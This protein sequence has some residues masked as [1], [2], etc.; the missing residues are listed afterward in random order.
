[1]ATAHLV[2]QDFT[3]VRGLDRRYGILLYHVTGIAGPTS[4]G[5]GPVWSQSNTNQT[6]FSAIPFTLG[7][8]HPDPG[9]TGA[10]CTSIRLVSGPWWQPDGT[11]EAMV[12][13]MFDSNR[14]WGSAFRESWSSDPA[15]EKAM[16]LAWT[17]VS[18][19]S[20]HPNWLEYAVP[21]V[22]PAFV[23]IVPC[24]ATGIT[25]DQKAQIYKAV[26]QKFTLFGIPYVFRT[27]LLVHTRTDQV[28]V[29][30]QFFTKCPVAAIAAGAIPGVDTDIPKL[31][32]LEEYTRV[33]SV[34][35]GDPSIQ[36]QPVTAYGADHDPT[37]LPF[38]GNQ[39]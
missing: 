26:G 11:G 13:V 28:I 7:Q 35:A 3:A 16:R 31:D 39:L 17:D 34:G 14:R 1:M 15:D 32:F 37:L 20:D 2:E 33:P 36:V 8:L 18:L 5:L 24:D 29:R 38:W 23:R 6:V 10:I 12:S 30:Y 21:Y 27:P 22:R 4:V 25:E 9:I 19:T